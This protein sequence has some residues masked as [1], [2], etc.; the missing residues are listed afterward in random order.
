MKWSPNQQKAI[1]TLGRNVVVSASAGAG[2]TA[3][4]TQRL[5]KRVAYDHV[6]VTSILAMT[7]TEAAAAEMKSRL[8]TSLNTLLKD[9]KDEHQRQ[10]LQ[11]Q[12]VLLG[13]AHVSTIHSFCLSIIKENYFMIGLDPKTASN[14]LSDEECLLLKEEAWNLSV[15]EMVRAF[16]RFHITVRLF[17]RQKR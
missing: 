11:D 3:V 2:K 15:D 7:F 14:I 10:F 1:E 9:E 13:N 4:L 6:P 17:Q 5:T 16:I 8:F 12:L